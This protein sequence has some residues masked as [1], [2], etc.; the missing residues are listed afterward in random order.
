MLVCVCVSALTC[1]VMAADV[2]IMAAGDDVT[3]GVTGRQLLMSAQGEW[4]VAS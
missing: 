3:A 2:T 1:C 4:C